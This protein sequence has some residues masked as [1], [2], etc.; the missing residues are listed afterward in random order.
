[1]SITALTKFVDLDPIT[2]IESIYKNKT[3]TVTLT[4]NVLTVTSTSNSNN[5]G[6]KIKSILIPRNSVCRI[7]VTG[8]ASS[9]TEAY[10]W[11][12][13]ESLERDIIGINDM[14]LLDTNTSSTIEYIL[15][16]NSRG[17][18]INAGVYFKSPVSGDQF[19]LTCICVEQL[20]TINLDKTASSIRYA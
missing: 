3:P 1:M 5:Q 15:R 16:G 7:Y 12:Y 20:A 4:N 9:S 11:V 10:L 14:Y 18:K 6:I 19:Q 13:N 2:K 17:Y 8:I